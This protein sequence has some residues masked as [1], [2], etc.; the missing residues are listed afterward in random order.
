MSIALDQY[1]AHRMSN[2]SR[3]EA[4]HN[5]HNT[6]GGCQSSQLCD[7]ASEALLLNEKQQHSFYSQV[8]TDGW[9]WELLSWLLAAV[10]LLVLIIVLAAFGNKALDQWKASITP[11]T[12]VSIVSQIGQTAILAPVTACI[13]QSMW[14]WLG[15]KN[16][17]NRKHPRLM[18][19]QEYDDGGRGP[20]GSLLLLWKHP[21]L[22]VP[23]CLSHKRVC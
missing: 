1:P 3:D 9:G 4:P 22:Y 7:Q 14:L 13:C 23:Q 6:N 15:G 20:V 18:D 19:M 17:Y 12:V 21:G 11:N 16:K 10:S 2:V 5:H 8:F